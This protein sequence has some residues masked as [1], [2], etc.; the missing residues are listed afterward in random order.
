VTRLFGLGLRRVYIG[1]ETGH[2]PL[3]ALLGKPGH[4]KELL[5]WPRP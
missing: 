1:L 4:P 3:L 2:A 5:P